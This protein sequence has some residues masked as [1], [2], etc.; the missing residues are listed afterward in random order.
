M[1]LLEVKLK[2]ILRIPLLFA[3]LAFFS[4]VILSI[5]N[6]FEASTKTHCNVPNYLP[7]ISASI[8]DFKPQTYIWRI[9]IALH[10]FPR[11]MM[12]ILY[13]NYY[14]IKFGDR[15]SMK[16]KVA[17]AFNSLL[18]IIENLALLIL[19]YVSSSENFQIHRNAF[20]TFMLS[21]MSYMLST[22]FL[23]KWTS[24]TPMTNDEIQSL[25]EKSIL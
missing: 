18:T 19:T 17:N 20:I 22:S 4:C 1:K 6:N 8:G 10:C 16:F 25:E 24:S 2:Y 3:L 11:I 14:T 7:S 9:C 5:V 15:T 12:S 21:S 13:Y 23:Y